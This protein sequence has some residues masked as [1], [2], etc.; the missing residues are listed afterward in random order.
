M[1]KKSG[2]T[3]EMDMNFEAELEN[4][5]KADFGDLDEGTIVPGSVVKVD[6][7]HVL[8]D[9][10]F[11]SEGQIPLSEFMDSEGN[12]TVAVGDKVDVFVSNK[13]GQVDGAFGFILVGQGR[14]LRVQQG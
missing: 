11:K 7:D 8:V 10:N 4:Y 3:P 12:V 5:L 1:E 9:V 14:C 2:T 6:R 13:D